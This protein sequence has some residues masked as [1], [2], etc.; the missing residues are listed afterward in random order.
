MGEFN[1]GVKRSGRGGG[2]RFGDRSDRGGDRG[3]RFGDRPEMHSAIC[4]NC[5]KECQ[6]PFRPTSGKPVYCSDCFRDKQGAEPRRPAGR[7][8][9][10]PPRFE[11][12][13]QRPP[14][15]ERRPD[16]GV[17]REQFEQLNAKLDKILKMLTPN[18]PTEKAVVAEPVSPNVAVGDQVEKPKKK[19]KVSKKT[20]SKD[21]TTEIS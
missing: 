5:G 21:S 12:P 13:P 14:F 4:D 10:R 6:V 18:V 19:R 1:R 3:G 7:D 8:F 20:S 16:A 2:F 9:S 15:I 17:S 11:G